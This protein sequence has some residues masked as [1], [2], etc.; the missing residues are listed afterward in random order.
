[1]IEGPIAVCSN[2][3]VPGSGAPSSAHGLR[4]SGLRDGLV[5]AGYEVDIVSPSSSVMAQ[6]HRWG[7]RRM[8]IPGH[9]R[10]LGDEQYARR[11][12]TDYA[13]VIFPNWPV[14]RRFQRSDDVRIIYDFFSATL[15]EHAMIADHESLQQ[16]RSEKL[17]LIEQAAIVIGNGE[18]QTRYAKEFL[19]REAKR[20]PKGDIPA[21]RL[22]LP[23]R[24]PTP[25]KAHRLRLFFGGFL[26]AWTTGISLVELEALA[27]DLDLD[28]HAIGL[29]QH[30]HF[31]DLSKI[32]R[33]RPRSA[34]VILHEVSSFEGYQDLNH[35]ADVA[36]DVFEPNPEREISYSTRAISSLACGCPLITMGFTEIGRLVEETGA[37]WTL[38]EFSIEA[39]R[40]R[41]TTLKANPQLVAK[42]RTKTR[43]FWTAYIDP[44]RQAKPL[45]S[46]LESGVSNV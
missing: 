2:A 46:M 25:T 8:S 24:A 38:D 5:A 45:V 21:V 26:Q 9:W 34:H 22:G 17:S 4:A 13:A 43:D 12:N 42:A 28:V 19:T 44:V 1:M 6:L 27:D 30:A 11:L 10:I 14:A 40:D 41:L 29:G 35:G 33:Y 16:K 15:V 31:R 37:G 32:G 36:L 20:P 39:L 7:S 18:V 3:I 23:Y